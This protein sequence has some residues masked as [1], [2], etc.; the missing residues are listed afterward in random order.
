MC[1]AVVYCC[2]FVGASSQHLG[3][4]SSMF[5]ICK[6]LGVQRRAKQRKEL[7]LD[8][9]DSDKED[10]TDP[11]ASHLGAQDA[12][13]PSGD[14]K[15]GPATVHQFHGGGVTTTVSTAPITLHSSR[16]VPQTV[17]VLSCN[18]PFICHLR[19]FASFAVPKGRGIWANM[20]VQNLLSYSLL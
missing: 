4:V 14:E 20:L 15:S 6:C 13:Q 19:A 1:C 10:G 17:L 16:H 5:G 18:D 9:F 12:E 3:C 11:A 8:Q 2:S 7:N